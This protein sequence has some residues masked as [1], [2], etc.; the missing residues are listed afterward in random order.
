MK[1]KGKVERVGGRRIYSLY[2]APPSRFT[3]ATRAR[4]GEI[5]AGWTSSKF[6]ENVENIGIGVVLSISSSRDNFSPRSLYRVK[7][8]SDT[9]ST[10]KVGEQR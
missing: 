7:F 8:V 6:V 4:R 2:S 9:R 5:I 10:R 3:I 1:V